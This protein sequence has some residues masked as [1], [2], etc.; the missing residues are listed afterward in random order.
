MDISKSVKG[1]FTLSKAEAV[2]FT[3]AVWLAPANLFLSSRPSWSYLDGVFVD[4][5]APKL[6]GAL[7]MIWLWG[8]VKLLNLYQKGTFSTHQAKILDRVR[9][10]FRPFFSAPHYL[11]GGL[12]L[13]FLV[14]GRQVLLNPPWPSLAFLATTL[15]G[16]VLLAALLFADRRWISIRLRPAVVSAVFI[17]AVLAWQQIIN[18][19]PLGPYWLL[20]EPRFSAGYSLAASGLPGPWRILPYGS[21]PHPN[22]LAGWM[23][24]GIFALV[25]GKRTPLTLPLCLLFLSTLIAAESWTAFIS[26]GILLAALLSRRAVVQNLHLISRSKLAF[27]WPMAVSAALTGLW[28]GALWMLNQAGLGSTSISRRVDLLAAVWGRWPQWWLAG[29][30]L[31]QH[32]RLAKLAP[33]LVFQGR[34]LQPVHSSLLVLLAD[35]GIWVILLLFTFSLFVHYSYSAVVILLLGILPMFSLDHYAVTTS[36][37][38]FL[39][40]L[41]SYFVFNTF[42]PIRPV[43]R[44]TAPVALRE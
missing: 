29:T 8:L 43:S 16:P 17:Q 42:Y 1:F 6:P 5:W 28:N 37:G 31:M 39:L 13:L 25:S 14:A 34:F 12:S 26:L 11:V 27:V 18:Q 38:Q 2:V 22:V 24:L 4:Y 30:G 9:T 20:G 21:A 33:F 40:I 19:R 10:F 32:L 36:S 3:L 7:A 23:V 35:L 15:G 41:L 44:R